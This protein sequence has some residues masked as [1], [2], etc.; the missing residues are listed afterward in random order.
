MI[1]S[2]FP[3]RLQL[4]HSTPHL[5]F[6]SNEIIGGNEITNEKAP[7]SS[8]IMMVRSSNKQPL[9]SQPGRCPSVPMALSDR[10][11]PPRNPPHTTGISRRLRIP[12]WSFK[13]K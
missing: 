11:L 2:F 3:G 12:R 10:P 5:Y 1:G 8:A 6:P 13:L 7:S 9:G 4:V